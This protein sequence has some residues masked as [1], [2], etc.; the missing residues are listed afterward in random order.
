MTVYPKKMLPAKRI[1]SFEDKQTES[2]V[3]LPRYT[4]LQIKEIK[5]SP[6]RQPGYSVING[7]G[8]GNLRI[9]N[10]SEI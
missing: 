7:Q 1:V 8:R 9:G 10:R 6:P 5:L 4:V 2:R 3:H